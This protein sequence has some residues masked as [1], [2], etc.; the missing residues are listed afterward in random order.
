MYRLPTYISLL[1]VSF[2]QKQCMVIANA[3]WFLVGD[4]YILYKFRYQLYIPYIS[5]SYS[6][7][8]KWIT[9]VEQYMIIVV[10]CLTG[11]T[12]VQEAGPMGHTHAR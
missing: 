12:G 6:I 4:T 3:C 10:T 1:Y 8:I 2:D 9:D 5:T 7:A 11:G